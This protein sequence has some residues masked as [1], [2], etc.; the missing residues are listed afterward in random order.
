M[1][2]AL[3]SFMFTL[4]TSAAYAAEEAAHSEPTIS[5]LL[6]PTI[7]FLVLLAFLVWK[8]KKP[9]Q[10]MF[11][12]KADEVQSLMTSAAQKNKDAESRLSALQEKMKNLDAE[13]TKIVAE[14][15][16][17]V[18]VFSKTHAEETQSTIAR[19]KKDLEHKLEGES[20]DLVERMHHDLLNNVI[21]KTQATIKANSDMKNR[22][23]GKIVS[24]LR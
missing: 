8:L 24:E 15:H 22:V 1:K 18:E 20:N 11:N 5:D 13:V 23:T 2:A 3:Y 7:N 19:T 14:Y 10:D 21:A 12:K 16:H 4:L 17:D 6:Y 9:M